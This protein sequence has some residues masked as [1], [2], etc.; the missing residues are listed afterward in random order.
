MSRRND[1]HV[2]EVTK[3]NCDAGDLITFNLQGGIV[4]NS[5]TGTATQCGR[6]SA[7][8]ERNVRKNRSL[9]AN[10]TSHTQCSLLLDWVYTH[11]HGGCRPRFVVAG[12]L[13]GGPAAGAHAPRCLVIEYNRHS[14][15]WLWSTEVHSTFTSVM[16]VDGCVSRCRWMRAKTEC[17]LF[18]RA[19]SS[20]KGMGSAISECTQASL[21]T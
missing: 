15:R 17:A 3:K 6:E 7:G 18:L 20:A 19:L 9:Q 11:L 4:K 10:S 16:R 2:A 14:E 1:T 5:M 8:E 12:F 21:E 13:E